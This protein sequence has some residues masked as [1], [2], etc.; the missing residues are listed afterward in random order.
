MSLENLSPELLE[1]MNACETKEQLIELVQE[2][3]VELTDEQIEEISG[4]GC[5]LVHLAS[6]FNNKECEPKRTVLFG[7]AKRKGGSDE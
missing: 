5:D 2:E 1:K 6:W 7:S 4:G 3:G